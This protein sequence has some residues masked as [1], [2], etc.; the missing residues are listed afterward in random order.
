MTGAGVENDH[1]A[2]SL[3]ETTCLRKG[4]SAQGKDGPKEATK[5]LDHAATASKNEGDS[6]GAILMAVHSIPGWQILGHPLRLG[7]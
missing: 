1:R 5:R 4:N 2:E 3:L 6:L 7:G